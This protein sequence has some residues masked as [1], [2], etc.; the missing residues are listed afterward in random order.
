MKNYDFVTNFAVDVVSKFSFD[1]GLDGESR[2]GGSISFDGSGL[3]RFGS[4]GSFSSGGFLGGRSS[5]GSGCTLLSCF[6]RCGAFGSLGGLLCPV[7]SKT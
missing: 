5:V 6:L 2:R 3:I 4:R 1:L 7:I